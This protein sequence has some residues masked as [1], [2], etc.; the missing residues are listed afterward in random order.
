VSEIN[1][2]KARF[3][4]ERKRKVLQRMRVREFRNALEGKTPKPTAAAPERDNPAVLTLQP[5]DSGQ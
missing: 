2:D 5:I 4:R 1:G 3:G